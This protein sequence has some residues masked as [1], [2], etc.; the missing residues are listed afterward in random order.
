MGRAVRVFVLVRSPLHATFHDRSIIFDKSETVAR[1][2]NYRRMVHIASE[3]NGCVTQGHL[4]NQSST[5]SVPITSIVQICEVIIA[6]EDGCPP[7][8]WHNNGAYRWV[9]LLR[10][11]LVCCILGWLL[12]GGE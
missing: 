10:I 3:D 6:A 2:V 4:Q 8:R 7:G 5:V 11:I 1:H 12:V 9:V